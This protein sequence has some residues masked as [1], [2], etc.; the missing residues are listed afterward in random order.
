M[1]PAQAGRQRPRT[2]GVVVDERGAQ[3]IAPGHLVGELVTGVELVEVAGRE[4]PVARH[5]RALAVEP[6]AAPV[7]AALRLIRHVVDVG[8]AA[9]PDER[10]RVGAEQR[11]GQ[12]GQGGL[13]LVHVA[14][15]VAL[16][17]LVVAPDVV[18]DLVV[19][20]Q[21]PDR[22]RVRRAAAR[23]RR[24]G[25]ERRARREQ[26]LHVVDGEGEVLLQGHLALPGDAG[27]AQVTAPAEPEQVQVLRI[28]DVVA[29]GLAEL[30]RGEVAQDISQLDR[31]RQVDIACHRG[32]R[33]QV[34]GGQVA[35]RGVRRPGP[36]SRRRR[37][38]R[39]ERQP[40][41]QGQGRALHR[42]GRPGRVAEAG[43]RAGDAVQGGQPA[44]VADVVEAELHAAHQVFREIPQGDAVL[45]AVVRVAVVRQ[46]PGNE[47]EVGDELPAERRPVGAEVGPGAEAQHDEPAVPDR[48]VVRRVVASDR[49]GDDPL[50]LV[51]VVRLDAQVLGRGDVEVGHALGQEGFLE[52]G[53]RQPELRHVERVR[54][55]DAALDERA[56][57]PADHLVADAELRRHV[58]QVETGVGEGV[59][60]ARVL[61]DQPFGARAEVGALGAVGLE[62][63]EAGAA[64][65][66]AVVV[67]VGQLDL[68]DRL[69]DVREQPRVVV[70]VAVVDVGAAPATAVRVGDD[71]AVPA[72]HAPLRAVA[73]GRVPAATP[74]AVVALERDRRSLAG[75]T[76][77]QHRGN[78]RRQ[79]P[80]AGRQGPGG[81]SAHLDSPAC[82]CVMHG[83]P[84]PGPAGSVPVVLP[85]PSP[86][87]NTLGQFPGGFRATGRIRCG[88]E[89]NGPAAGRRRARAA[90]CSA[91][92][93][94][95]MA[96]RMSCRS[97]SPRMIRASSIAL[98]SASS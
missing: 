97:R 5:R 9:F 79:D 78:G 37:D 34:R 21:G 6:Q 12:V 72:L 92:A 81:M 94:R 46:H 89:P 77:R 19:A 35:A 80:P 98:T 53:A 65:E 67:L 16:D 95:F 25:I 66:D 33:R 59:Q 41:G 28:G 87:N 11:A 17:H 44:M 39:V 15:D 23:R 47:V 68:G 48:E 63:V 1:G 57:A 61:L 86:E 74:V 64:H 20:A 38:R 62:V 56:L 8:Q 27:V 43:L 31:V 24:E 73:D 83:R 90:R 7:R 93:H 75:V 14:L 22:V 45:A 32:R 55:V 60:Q 52:L 85:N 29:G 4:R 51:L 26:Q 36:G 2:D 3:A 40:R 84:A 71:P 13:E 10:A 88:A 70:E 49:V 30:V 58:A 50:P 82:S 91:Q 96:C 69:H 42:R 18:A 76:R 54:Q